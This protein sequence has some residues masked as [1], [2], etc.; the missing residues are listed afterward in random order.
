MNH[1]IWIAATLVVA[2]AC[3][4]DVMEPT[5][6]TPGAASANLSEHQAAGHVYT[7]SNSASGNAVLAYTR[8]ADGSLTA[9][10]SVATTGKGTGAGLG[11]QGAV[12]LSADGRLL[13]AVDAGSNQIS[14]FLVTASG[15]SHVAT[16]SSH[17]AKPISV[18]LHGNW[19]YVLN[20][21][22]SGNI[23]GFRVSQTGDLTWISGSTRSLGGTAVDPAEVAFSP[24]G[25]LLA[26]TEK[27]VSKIATYVVNASGMAGAPIINASVGI[28]P[29]GF[30]FDL[31]GTLIVSEAF[32]GMPN[33]SATSTYRMNAD[34]TLRVSSSSV[35][36]H[37]TAACWAVVTDNG[38]YAYVSNTGSGS[39]SGYMVHDRRLAL[40]N[41]DGR[42]GV[43]GAG[44]ADAALSVN[45]QY[46]Y[47]RSGGSN[48]ISAFQLQ[49]GSGALTSLAGASGLPAGSV[50]LAAN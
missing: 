44:P 7:L 28:T 6:P 2:S 37:Q 24:D 41:A 16:V 27:A 17:G 34:G 14:S 26:V 42:T 10:G 40:L 4:R 15:L 29:F 20:A 35:A 50:G 9:A 45:S 22:E 32:G 23:T 11:S 3:G 21:G 1:R 43:S 49:P 47:V 31:N 18:T 38:Q 12:I 33:A 8:A 48:S 19:L 30:T 46:L 36:T 13:F 39:V 5:T 25:R